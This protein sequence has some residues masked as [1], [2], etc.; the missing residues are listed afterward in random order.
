MLDDLLSN[1]LLKYAN[2][3][4]SRFD[5]HIS[6]SDDEKKISLEIINLIN[7]S[8]L[9]ALS[10]NELSDSF[11]KYNKNTIKKIL[12]IEIANGNIIIINGNF[13]FSEK[14][15]KKLIELVKKYF[16]NNDSLDVGSFKKITSTSR[17]YAVPLLEY[18]DKINI[19]CRIGNERK[20]QG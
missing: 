3:N 18:L 2:N 20:L 12:D 8:K 15:I 16:I 1:K 9:N 5:F 11:I 4:W 13:I 10:I 17:K 6:L 19:T 14:N 7:K